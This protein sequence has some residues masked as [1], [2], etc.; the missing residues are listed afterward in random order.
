[1]CVWTCMYTWGY[2]LL[3]LYIYIYIY[4][5]TYRERERKRE[6]GR[7]NNRKLIWKGY[8][9]FL[10]SCVTCFV[11]QGFMFCHNNQTGKVYIYIYIYIYTSGVRKNL[12]RFPQTGSALFLLA[13]H[14]VIGWLFSSSTNVFSLYFL[15]WKIFPPDKFV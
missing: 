8:K 2:I 9:L 4:I 5:Y 7:E 13:R 3:L 12:P 15:L 1:M 14:Y 11:T 10:W 6:R